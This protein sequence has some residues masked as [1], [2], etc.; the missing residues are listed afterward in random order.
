MIHWATYL[1]CLAHRFILLIMVARTLD[2]GT[3]AGLVKVGADGKN[4]ERY[5]PGVHK[6]IISEEIYWLA[7][8][9]LGTK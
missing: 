1:N 5:V 2:N 6:A 9:K 4:P 7:Q 8:E 3:Y